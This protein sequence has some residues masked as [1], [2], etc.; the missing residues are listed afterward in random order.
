MKRLP[1]LILA[2]LAGWLS[3][4]SGARAGTDAA[5]ATFEQR[6]GEALPLDTTFTDTSGQAHRLGD[7]FHGQ[8]VLMI[9]GYANCPQLCSIVADGTDRALRRLEPS[10]GRDFQVVYLSIDPQETLAEASAAR[11]RSVGRYGRTGAG[12]GWHYLT[13]TA[14]AIGAVT[15]AAG[16]HFLPD[17]AARRFSHPSGFLIATP[18]GVISRYFLGVDFPA[19][20]VDRALHRAAEGKTGRTVFALLLL[21]AR[22][23]QLTGRY[24]PLIWDILCAGV[25]LTVGSLAG[26]VA[27]ML[28]R[29]RRPSRRKE[30]P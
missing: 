25:V 5:A 3:L 9:F 30:S 22:G 2:A 16:F 11:K 15:D 21:C 8:P 14:D 29:E 17:P 26:G 20:D 7:Y 19:K 10:V 27:W 28:W 1:C 18:S 12:A 24:G 23:G 6:I 4:T 13:G